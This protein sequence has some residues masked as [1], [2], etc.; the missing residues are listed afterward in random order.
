MSSFKSELLIAAA[1]GAGAALLL[2]QL[3]ASR[4][5]AAAAAA[6]EALSTTS[7]GHSGSVYETDKAVAEYLMFHFGA[8]GDI[9][10][11]AEGPH[12]ALEF[13][14]RCVRRVEEK[15]GRGSPGAVGLP[16][17]SRTHPSCA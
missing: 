15:R 3:L 1:A 16:R 9:L 8:P 13:A 5:A 14:S 6:S 2:Q 7:S 10:P 4:A 12:A 17:R 11:Y